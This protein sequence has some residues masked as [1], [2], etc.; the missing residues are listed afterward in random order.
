MIRNSTHKA[1]LVTALFSVF[2]LIG[3]FG[4]SWN[5]FRFVLFALLLVHTFFSVRC[6]SALI[7]PRDLRQ[8]MVDVLLVIAYFLT[9]AFMNSGSLF[10]M[11]WIALFFLATLKYILLIGRLD[12]PKLLRRKL[13]ADVGGLALGFFVFSI[14]PNS[15]SFVAVL[16]CL[17][18]GYYLL[19]NPLYVPDEKV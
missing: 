5:S 12:H 10:Y 9:G 2:G 14:W 4:S 7:D 16:F 18:S 17:A 15:E 3:L 13:I 19:F 6:F 11:G 1:V 8:N